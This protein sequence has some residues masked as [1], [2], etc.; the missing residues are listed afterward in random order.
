MKKAVKCDKII[1]ANIVKEGAVDSLYCLWFG[2]HK[3]YNMDQLRKNFDFDNVEMYYLGGSLSRWL[4]QC[5]ENETAE[6]VENIN[7]LGDISKQLAEIF[8]VKLPKGRSNFPTA[9]L[10]VE[11]SDK[12]QQNKTNSFTCTEVCSAI[13][14]NIGLSTFNSKIGSF[15]LITE[16]FYTETGSFISNANSFT[17]N[18][19]YTLSHSFSI[20]NGSFETTSF[21]NILELSSFGI[22]GSSFTSSSFYLHEYEYEYGRSFNFF[23]FKQKSFDSENLS[24]TIKSKKYGASLFGNKNRNYRANITQLSDEEKIKLNIMYCPLNR[25]GYGI[26]LI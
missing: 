10:S 17:L 12:S 21:Q 16:S 11:N 19:F 24:D 25:F 23:G 9:T 4:R 3:I 6:K 15:K 22:S 14:K 8:S 2:N 13:A 1:G 7:P 26:D 18:S 5:G 20:F